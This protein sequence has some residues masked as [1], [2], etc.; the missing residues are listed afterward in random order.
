MST[1]PTRVSPPSSATG[2]SRA[3][4]SPGKLNVDPELEL[5]AASG[6][7]R[8]RVEEAERL[9]AR[10][11]RTWSELPLGLQDGYFDAAKGTY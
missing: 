10:D 4:T 2:S 9:A 7:F 6:R 1:S 3:S 11:G 5:R 8:S